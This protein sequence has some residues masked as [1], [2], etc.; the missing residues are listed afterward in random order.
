MAEIGAFFLST[1]FNIE[2]DIENHAS[3]VQSWQKHLDEKD[4][5]RATNNA[6][7]AFHFLVE[8]LLSDELQQ[9]A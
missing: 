5:M 9:A 4:I 2:S 1:F 7:K 6:A 8:P 3:Y